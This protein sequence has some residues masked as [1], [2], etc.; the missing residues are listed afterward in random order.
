MLNDPAVTKKA[1]VIEQAGKLQVI[2]SDLSKEGAVSFLDRAAAF[3][4][5]F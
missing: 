3:L 1:V 4:Q 2:T 5:A